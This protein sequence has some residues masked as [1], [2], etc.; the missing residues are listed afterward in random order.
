M[1]YQFGFQYS[2]WPAFVVVI[3]IIL[4]ILFG[5][6]WKAMTWQQKRD[7]SALV[8]VVLTLILLPFHFYGQYSLVG[9]ENGGMEVT[10][11][12]VSLNPHESITSLRLANIHAINPVGMIVHLIPSDSNISFYLIDEN[13]PQVRQ[14]ETVLSD[15]EF[16]DFRLP[17]VF[18]NLATPARWTYCLLN[19]NDNL[20]VE[21]ILAISVL[22]VN[23]ILQPDP[24]FIYRFPTIALYTVWFIWSI[25]IL[26]SYM[27]MWRKLEPKKT[28][29]VSQEINDGEDHEPT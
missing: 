8:V 24:L 29:D 11:T 10:G 6:R 5:E 20:S 13:L 12:I 14:Q 19:P 23:V 18:S 2:S 9:I 26:I 27:N 3:I 7:N 21:V 28:P 22:Q 1:L 17:Y 4:Y 25:L 16:F 15:G